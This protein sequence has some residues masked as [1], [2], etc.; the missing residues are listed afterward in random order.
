MTNMIILNIINFIAVW[1]VFVL[2]MLFID[3]FNFKEQDR[4]QKTLIG[5]LF[6]MFVGISIVVLF[7]ETYTILKAIVQQEI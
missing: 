5:I 1:V 4:F 6:F 3:G 2:F 7:P